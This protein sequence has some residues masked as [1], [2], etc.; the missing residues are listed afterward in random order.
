MCIDRYPNTGEEKMKFSR[1]LRT[2]SKKPT[3]HMGYVNNA[4]TV[5]LVAL[6]IYM[7]YITRSLVMPFV[8]AMFIFFILTNME[9]SFCKILDRRFPLLLD[10]IPLPLSKRVKH[11][12]K[13]VSALLLSIVLLLALGV[14]CV[15]IV[16]NN[17]SSVVQN[18]PKYQRKFDEKITALN[19]G[20]S[21]RQ[22]AQL[23]ANSLPQESLPQES[24]PQESYVQR[25]LQ[26]LP[27]VH[28]PSI[29]MEFLKGMDLTHTLTSF[30]AIVTTSFK[31]TG[32]VI[33]YLL[34]L[35][36]ERKHLM[37]KIRKI[38]RENPRF[39]DLD[40]MLA[41]INNGLLEYLKIKTIASVSTGILSYMVL[42][43]V[44][45]DFAS[46]WAFII[47]ILNYIPT[48]GSIVAVILPVTLAFVQ[49]DSPGTIMFVIFGLTGIQFMIGN[50]I[51]PR[52]QGSQL[53]LSPLIILLSLGVWG[54]I[55]GIMG[56]FLSV[57]IM[58]T[59]NIILARFESTRTL[60]I[61]LT[62][63][64]K[65]YDEDDEETRR[66]KKKT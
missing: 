18:A 4:F 56:M 29:S 53:N 14:A 25:L 45:L 49:F 7:L 10:Q 3:V 59:F 31:N 64:G 38:Q 24:L 16:N 54:K 15:S 35:F 58:V 13:H 52:F 8:I 5:I 34:F 6:G 60:A 9:N 19:E 37:L 1:K 46:F 62:S 2:S 17:F 40:K 41:K 66:K 39:F 51:E 44:Q 28:L 27:P 48:I 21:L 32:M 50:V 43:A 55:W 42:A 22:Q 33:I 12:I 63:N 26:H 57:P 20:L 61:I 11:N 47:V 23:P 65:L 36:L 30:G